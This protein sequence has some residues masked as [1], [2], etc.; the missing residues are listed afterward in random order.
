MRGIVSI[1]IMAQL[2]AG[3][4][5]SRSEWVSLCLHTS[6]VHKERPSDFKVNFD[7]P[8]T[9]NATF[10]TGTLDWRPSYYGKDRFSVEVTPSMGGDHPE[11]AVFVIDSNNKATVMD[12]YCFVD[13]KKQEFTIPRATRPM[14]KHG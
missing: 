2:L 5:K 8:L 6:V 12:R 11:I 3:C 13:V 1:L 10:Y 4:T 7:A 14:M 9:E